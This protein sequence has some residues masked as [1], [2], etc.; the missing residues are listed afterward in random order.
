MTYKTIF[1]NYPT[2][3]K[4]WIYG[5]KNRLD[6]E[7]KVIVQNKLNAFKNNWLYHGKP[8]L[9]DFEIIENRFA[10]L[11]TNDQISGCS[12][13]SSVSVFKELSEQHDL[14]ALDYNAIFFRDELGNIKH[15]DRSDFQEIANAN[16]VDENTIVFNFT[17]TTLT[18]L[19]AGKF[20]G[21]AMNS[22][23]AKAFKIKTLT[24]TV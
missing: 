19:Q 22:W 4:I 7:Q 1:Q 10:I 5:F 11:I 13:D 24:P 8:V 23:H 21:P 2:D 18:D 16:K 3:S 6:E 12:I 20:E 9:G 17:I 15:T 14:D